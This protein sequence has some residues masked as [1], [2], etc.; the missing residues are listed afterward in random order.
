MLAE[1]K[2][3]GKRHVV[4]MAKIASNK[5][6]GYLA[7]Q[8]YKRKNCLFHYSINSITMKVNAMN[9]LEM[10]GMLDDAL[11]D[12]YNNSPRLD[13]RIR[14]DAAI[15]YKARHPAAVFGKPAKK[16]KPKSKNKIFSV[17]ISKKT[18]SII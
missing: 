15:A 6:P 12:I 11:F 10:T 8:V 3:I 16:F 14:S 9:I 13:R 2:K 7:T 18:N 4:K 17:K 1:V 5:R